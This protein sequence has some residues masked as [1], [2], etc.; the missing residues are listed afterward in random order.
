MTD[1]NPSANRA[2]D[3][4]SERLDAHMQ[5]LAQQ[6]F[7]R[8]MRQAAT[9]LSSGNGHDAI[10]LLERCYG[11]RPHDVNVLTNLGGAY[12]LAGKHRHAIPVLE[13]ATEL[14]TDNPAIWTNLAAAYLGKLVTASKEQRQRALAAYR[15]V[16]ELDPVYPNVHYN[17]GLIYIDQ[18]SWEQAETAFSDALRVNPHDEDA[19]LMRQR[20]T[21]ILNDDF[22]G[23]NS[24]AN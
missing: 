12:I 16:L 1:H 2:P 24:A 20:V 15:R 18:R 3:D 9:M 14:V 5:Q 4:D 19:R 21:E 8:D 13:H 6:Q 10:P 11:Q 22:D 23:D 7:M 17:M